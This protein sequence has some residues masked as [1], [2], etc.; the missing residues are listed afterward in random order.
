MERGTANPPPIPLALVV[1]KASKILSVSSKPG[2]LSITWTMISF[3]SVVAAA[4]FTSGGAGPPSWAS[5]AFESKLM[6]KLLD[7][8]QIDQDRRKWVIEA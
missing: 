5:I 2:P 8:N 4:T 3:W 6:K 1:T 7:L